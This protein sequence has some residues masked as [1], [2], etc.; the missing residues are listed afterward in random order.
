M[1][2]TWKVIFP[3]SDITSK[4]CIGR[5][6]FQRPRLRLLSKIEELA[7]ISVF[8]DRAFK[9]LWTLKIVRHP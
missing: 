7:K 1:E 4:K 2:K 6:I 8:P 3:G 5:P 9:L